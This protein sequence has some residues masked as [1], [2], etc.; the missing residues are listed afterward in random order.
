MSDDWSGR[1]E[2]Q[3]RLLE[4]ANTTRWNKDRIRWFLEHYKPVSGNRKD[5]YIRSLRQI[6]CLLGKSFNEMQKE[7]VGRL[8][9]AIEK[10]SREEWTFVDRKKIL[11]TFFR[12]YVE[13]IAD[14]PEKQEE[15]LRLVPVL[16]AV[17]KIESVYRKHR[18]KKLVIL[19]Q[20]E[21]REL[22]RAASDSARELAIVT[23]LYH[24][25]ARP[26]EFVRM[27]IGD[28]EVNGDG[29]VYFNVAGK[30][31]SRRL[32]LAAD[33]TVWR[34]LLNW[35][36][37]HPHGSDRESYLFLNARGEPL[38]LCT[39]S[40]M[41]SRLSQK[42]RI[43]TVTPK[44]LRKAKL[45]HMADDGYNAY[46]IKKYAGHSQIETA[47]FYV[48]LSQKGF[49]DAIRKKYGAA[50][51]TRATLQPQRCWKCGS[52][53]R[54]FDR[55]CAGCGRMLNLEE[56]SREISERSDLI[57]SVMTQDMLDQLARLVAEKLRETA[58]GTGLSEG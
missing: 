26:S 51:R 5:K 17:N 24:T 35:I 46:Q 29:S 23:M 3:Y 48:E 50:D 2:K 13:D 55:R 45:S 28:I 10:E 47:M 33:E 56:A 8:V 21:L 49:E 18:Q 34:T 42:A 6:A 54:A 4:E 58:A 41:L 43:R 57:A 12:F 30:T 36:N 27:K 22:C 1:L 44:L 14:R 31:G 19:T 25:G 20:E 16:K 11:K 15:Y 9:Q 32:P 7:D 38:S 40:L 37:E 39:L 52:T 53:N